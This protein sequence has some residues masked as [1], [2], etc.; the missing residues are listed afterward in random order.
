[1]TAPSLRPCFKAACV[2]I[3][4]SR[5]RLRKVFF[6]EPGLAQGAVVVGFMVVI[7]N[8]LC[9]SVFQIWGKSDY[10]GILSFLRAVAGNPLIVAC[11]IGGTLS[12][13]GIG[14]SPV[15]ENV[16][17]IPG[18]AALPLGLLAVGA[19]L[20]PE[21]IKGH[22]KPISGATF[23]QF[24]VK[25]LMAASLVGLTGLSGVTAA[26]LIIPLI[27]PTSP[28]SYI[29]ARQLGGDTEVMASIITFQTLLAFV[30]MPLLASL[31]ITL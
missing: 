18:R 28:S 14:L 20:K 13:T 10:K 21:L 24:G 17:E 29:L 1:M 31:L 27:T 6:G 5:S 30:V 15:A 3:P 23:V 12:L 4:I 19:A 22:F 7:A 25:P 9:V 11:V 2:S 8:L 26:V 16:F